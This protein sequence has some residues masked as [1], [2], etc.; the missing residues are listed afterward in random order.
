MSRGSLAARSLCRRPATAA[1]EIAQLGRDRRH[2]VAQE[3]GTP[4]ANCLMRPEVAPTGEN[5]ARLRSSDV[6]ADD[7]GD[8][9]SCVAD[10]GSD[11][12]HD[13][14]VAPKART[15]GGSPRGSHTSALS[16]RSQSRRAGS[17]ISA[18]RR[19]KTCKPQQIEARRR[20]PLMPRRG[21]M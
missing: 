2:L 3:Q 9:R 20:R 4:S 7:H 5:R 10:S 13:A 8:R 6:A 21:K 19:G 15:D 1:P 16:G 18:H 12:R 14:V 17:R 11:L